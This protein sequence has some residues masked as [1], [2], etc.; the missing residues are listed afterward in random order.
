[1]VND[2]KTFEP[3]KL[4]QKEASELWYCGYGWFRV[5]KPEGFAYDVYADSKLY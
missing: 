1:M 5:I 2:P 3:V 4:S